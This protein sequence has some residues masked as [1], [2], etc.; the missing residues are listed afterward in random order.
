VHLGKGF[1]YSLAGTTFVT[2]LC[3]GYFHFWDEYVY[4]R[5]RLN[6]LKG[7]ELRQLE[8]LQFQRDEQECCY[9][10][11]FKDY[12]HVVSPYP[13]LGEGCSLSLS[14]F[15][16]PVEE[17]M[18][19]LENLN[20]GYQLMFAESPISIERVLSTTDKKITSFQ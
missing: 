8:T 1:L 9:N 14:S 18:Q 10:G 13:I 17:N 11:I 7:K 6:F 4:P 12:H 5:R 19:D 20:E 2:L 3:G 15:I 16:A